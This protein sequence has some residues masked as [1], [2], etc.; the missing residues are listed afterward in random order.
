MK[1]TKMKQKK[2]LNSRCRSTRES[3][4]MFSTSWG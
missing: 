1:A 3:L 4:M 2:R